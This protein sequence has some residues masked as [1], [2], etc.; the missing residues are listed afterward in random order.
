VV[1]SIFDL[2]C[3]SGEGVTWRLAAAGPRVPRREKDFSEGCGSGSGRRPGEVR[4]CSGKQR[5]WSIRPLQG[6]SKDEMNASTAER[7]A[8]G[9]DACVEREPSGA[10]RWGPPCAEP[11]ENGWRRVAPSRI[12]PSVA[13]HGDAT[14]SPRRRLQPATTVAGHVR[15]TLGIRV[16]PIFAAGARTTASRTRTNPSARVSEA[17]NGSRACGMPRASVPCSVR[18]TN[19]PSTLQDLRGGLGVTVKAAERPHNP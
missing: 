13:L 17:C 14:P 2:P 11:G 3:L 4:Q 8:E 16:R 19:P 9:R 5:A 15:R 6:T 12:P 7:A 10:V 18:S 1:M